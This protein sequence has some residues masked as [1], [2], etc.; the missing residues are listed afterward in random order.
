M[1]WLWAI[2][3]S[4]ADEKE[5]HCGNLQGVGT[6]LQ[7]CQ[8][9]SFVALWKYSS[10]KSQGFLYAHVSKFLEA[11]DQFNYGIMPAAGIS[12]GLGLV[13]AVGHWDK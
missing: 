1:T 13:D 9:V 5:G 10:G 12:E 2:V 6:S 3:L 7:E 11:G 4:L 8:A